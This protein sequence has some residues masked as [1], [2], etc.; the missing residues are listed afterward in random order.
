MFAIVRIRNKDKENSNNCKPN[1]FFPLR[2]SYLCSLLDRRQCWTH[3][4]RWRKWQH[5]DFYVYSKLSNSV[6]NVSKCSRNRWS[7]FQFHFCK[8]RISGTLSFYFYFFIFRSSVVQVK[9]SKNIEYQQLLN[10]P[11]R[12]GST[13]FFFQ[14]HFLCVIFCS[15]PSSYV[16]SCIELSRF[17]SWILREKQKKCEENQQSTGRRKCDSGRIDQISVIECWRQ[18]SKI[19]N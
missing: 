17:R 19:Q 4:L 11:Q 16:C 10:Q 6:V 2:L 12:F 5:Y 15:P 13:N 18:R 8:H 7:A 9:E 1:R 3:S 14:I